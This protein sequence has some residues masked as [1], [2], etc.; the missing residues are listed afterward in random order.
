MRARAD[1]QGHI[2]VPKT[3]FELLY[4]EEYETGIYYFS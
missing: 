4:S 1:E 3:I 2:L